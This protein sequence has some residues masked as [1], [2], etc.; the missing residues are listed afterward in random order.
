MRRINAREQCGCR[1][2]SALAPVEH[3][4]M[5]SEQRRLMAWL[6]GEGSLAM[7]GVPSAPS[8]RCAALS[9]VWQKGG[10]R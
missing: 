1:F 5:P 10:V 2:R 3:G 6:A 7:A 8:E 9:E 4:P